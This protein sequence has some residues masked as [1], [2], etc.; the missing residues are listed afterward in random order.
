MKKSLRKKLLSIRKEI[1]EENLE[2]K[3]KKIFEN[4]IKSEILNNKK[5]V[6][7]YM[8][9]RNEVKT[10][11]L[12]KYLFENNY[13]VILPRVNFKTGFLDLFHVSSLDSMVL[14]SY[15]I[16]E[17]TPEKSEYASVK[18]IDLIFVPGVGFDKRFYRIGYGGGYYDKLLPETENCIF[19]ALAFDEQMLDEVAKDD[20]DVQMDMIITDSFVLKKS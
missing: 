8:D 10:L 2:I 16:L 15:G 20:Y 6:M 13:N 12:I 5:N 18:D 1:S 3:S 4:I 14:S 7:V 19:C 17:P 9:F 11:E